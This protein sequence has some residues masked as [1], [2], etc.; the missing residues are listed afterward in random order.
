[1]VE[2]L[3]IVLIFITTSSNLAIYHQSPHYMGLKGFSSLRPHIKDKLQ[4]IKAFKQLI[5]NFLE[6]NTFYTLDKYFNYNKKKTL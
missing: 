1:M 5:K 3:D 2:I 4:N 6:C